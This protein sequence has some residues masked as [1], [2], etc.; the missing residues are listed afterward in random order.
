MSD[1]HNHFT[2]EATR[3][4][5]LLCTCSTL[6]FSGERMIRFVPT[7]PVE[8]LVD[9]A[10]RILRSMSLKSPNGSICCLHNRIQAVAQRY[11]VKSVDSPK[12][13]SITPPGNV[14]S[15]LIICCCSSSSGDLVFYNDELHITVVTSI[16]QVIQLYFYNTQNL[17]YTVD[18]LQLCLTHTSQCCSFTFLDH[19]QKYETRHV[20]SSRGNLPFCVMLPLATPA[21]AT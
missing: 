8:V 7:V 14:K 4:V 10:M 17:L 9:L 20:G 12:S 1:P 11:C 2:L 19:S 18:S 15:Y 5:D 3:T 6:T 21:M 13:F 16:F